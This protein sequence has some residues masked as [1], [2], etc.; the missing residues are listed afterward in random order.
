MAKLGI[1]DF[2]TYADKVAAIAQTIKG[3]FGTGDNPGSPD[4]PS[5]SAQSIEDAIRGLSDSD[6]IIDLLAAARSF[7]DRMLGERVKKELLGTFGRALDLHVGGI[8]SYLDAN[9]DGEGNPQQVSPEFRDAVGLVGAE[10]VFPP[11]ITD[12]GSFSVTGSG[13]G[14]FSDGS[15]VDTSLYGGTEIEIITTAAIGA[16]N[17]DV[18]IVGTDWDGNTVNRTATVPSGTSNGATVAVDAGVFLVDVTDI[19]IVGGTSGDSFRVDGKLRRT[20]AL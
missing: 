17:I 6:P 18:T 2:T 1:S 15:A 3:D 7:A 5:D 16:A 20:I 4:D 13:A 10:H 8:P 19:T 9:A 14:T 11:A 12:M